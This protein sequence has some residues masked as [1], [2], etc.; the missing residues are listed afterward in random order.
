[1]LRDAGHDVYDFR[2]PENASGFQWKSLDPEWQNWT[3]REY[4][5]NLLKNPLASHGYLN[6]MRAMEW[7]D[8]CVLLLPCGRSAHLEAGWFAGRGKRL[9]I[10]TQDGEEP[11]LMAL[12]ANH[13]CISPREVIA[14]LK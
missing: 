3:A 7:A 4:R 10:L 8:T 12:M 2:N 1:M 14:I 13:I 11:E 6:D 5:V 9:I